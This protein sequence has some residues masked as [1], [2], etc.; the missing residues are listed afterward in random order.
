M[1]AHLLVEQTKIVVGGGPVLLNTAGITGAYVSMKNY[2][3]LTAIVALAPASG[4]DTAAITAKQATAIA[5]TSAKALGFSNIW[6]NGAPG[7]NDTLVKT[8]VVAN[9]VTTSALAAL[10]LYVIEI[11]AADLDV[12]NGFDCV[13]IDVSD[14]G[15][16]STPASII[17]ILSQPRYGQSTPPSAVI[18]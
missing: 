5:G 14:P 9:S 2:N 6:K 18:D 15:S 13:G 4:T 7:T 3:H 1:D 17:Y 8:A 16:V 10:E 11:D 12:A